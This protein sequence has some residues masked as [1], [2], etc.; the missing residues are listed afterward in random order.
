MLEITAALTLMLWTLGLFSGSVL[1]AAFYV[2]P[3][4][5][6]TALGLRVYES[7]RNHAH[8]TVAAPRP[9]I[10]PARSAQPAAQSRSATEHARAA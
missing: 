3:V 10:A 6:L 2:L 4:V 5:A 7:L 9:E 8:E 1:G